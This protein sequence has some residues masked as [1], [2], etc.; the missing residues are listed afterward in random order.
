MG[1]TI[2]DGKAGTRGQ[3]NLPSDDRISTHKVMFEVKEV[4]GAT[5]PA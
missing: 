3:G 2:R 1:A 4:H 5:T